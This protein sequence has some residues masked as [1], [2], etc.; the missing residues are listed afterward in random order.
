MNMS[1]SSLHNLIAH[2]LA[3]NYP[4][5]LPP[6]LGAT[7]IPPPDLTNPPVPDLPTLVADAVSAQLAQQL[8]A[9]SLSAGID[10]EQ[11]LA[12]LVKAPLPPTATLGAVIRSVD[13]VSAANLLA[14]KVATLPRRT[15]DTA[16]A[17]YHAQWVKSIVAASADKA[18]RVIDYATGEVRAVE[19]RSRVY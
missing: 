8:A 12:E 5:A 3:Q 16:T 9:T 18:I 17:S 1:T 6:F 2:Y 19:G 4:L 13:D 11:T 10:G 15:F 14:V 7:G